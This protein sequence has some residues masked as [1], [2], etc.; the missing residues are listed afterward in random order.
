MHGWDTEVRRKY[1]FAI[2]RA[3][4]NHLARCRITGCAWAQLRDDYRLTAVQSVYVATAG[5]VRAEDCDS[6]RWVWLPQLQKA[7][8]A[9]FDLQCAEL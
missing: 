8:R 1:E 7:M 6:M 4:H 5:C 3:Y 9:F 2:L